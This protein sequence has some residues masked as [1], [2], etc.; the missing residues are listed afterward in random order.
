MWVGQTG[1]QRMWM[2]RS[3]EQMGRLG[4]QVGRSNI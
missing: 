1:E 2:S 3:G 4:G